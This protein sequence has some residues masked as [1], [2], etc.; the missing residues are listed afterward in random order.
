MPLAETPGDQRNVEEGEAEKRAH[1]EKP[2]GRAQRIVDAEYANDG[3]VSDARQRDDK[4][5]EL[6][7]P[8]G[9]NLH[10]IL[11]GGD[12][13]VGERVGD[14]QAL[15]GPER[16]RRLEDHQAKEECD[17]ASDGEEQE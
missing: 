8:F 2:A 9:V 16:E 5:E 13:S 6:P 10:R 7:Q 4:G 15:D 14:L 1:V 17:T 11:R 12:A 3:E